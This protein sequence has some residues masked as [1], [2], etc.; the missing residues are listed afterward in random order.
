MAARLNP[1]YFHAYF[2]VTPRGLRVP[3][4][5]AV[6]TAHDAL[7][8]KTSAAVN[9]RRDAALRRELKR[10][11]IAHF[12]VTGG[13]RDGAHREPG[14]GLVAPPDF[15]RALAARWRQRAYFWISGD[16]VYL[17]AASGGPLRRA[18]TW[19]ARRASWR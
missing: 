5:F 16:R 8:R 4:R 10:L 6:V 7:G 13:S 2:S 19:S 18:G 12:R 1:A 15:A 9:R 3:A 14:W 11:K 17:G